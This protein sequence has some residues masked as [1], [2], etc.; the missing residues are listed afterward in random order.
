MKLAEALTQINENLKVIKKLLVLQ[1]L[2]PEFWEIKLTDV[3]TPITIPAG[4]KKVL[5]DEKEVGR[6]IA[7]VARVD[8]PDVAVEVRIDNTIAKSTLRELYTIGL[9]SF[10]PS[11]FWVSKFDPQ[12]NAYVAVYTP[13][14]PREYFKHVKV[15]VYAPSDS[16]V[17]LLYS[18]YRYKVKE[19][20]L[21]LLTDLQST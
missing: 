17:Q 15:T 8:N 11:T 5:V 6:L 4:C 14:P 18:I 10:N 7:V 2:S 16:P 21:E 13:T 12:N 9:N 20:A 3:D 1:T 19:Q